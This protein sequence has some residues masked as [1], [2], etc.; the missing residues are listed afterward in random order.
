MSSVGE[1]IMMVRGK[2]SREKFAARIDIS[3]ATL[4]RYEY[5]DYPIPDRFL[6]FFAAE[7]GISLEWLL[8]GNGDMYEQKVEKMTNQKESSH[9]ELLAVL[10][11]QIETQRRH[12]AALEQ[13]TALA[14]FAADALQRENEALR[15]Q[16]EA[17]QRQVTMLE[18]L[19][20]AERQKEPEAAVNRMSAAG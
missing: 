2:E 13:N 5:E 16:L 9:D 12:I 4:K 3:A 1:R 10:R 6:H 19:L 7:M 14:K 20:A 15:G 11:E 8:T 17:T 18:D